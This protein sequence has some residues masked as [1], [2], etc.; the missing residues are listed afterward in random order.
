M[1]CIM[2]SDIGKQALC[3]RKDVSFAHKTVLLKYCDF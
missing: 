2:L 3:N 1:D